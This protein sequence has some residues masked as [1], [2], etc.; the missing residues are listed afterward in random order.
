MIIS[1]NE[2]QSDGWFEDRLGLPTASNFSK[3]VTSKGVASKSQ[4]EYR[5][6]LASEI[7]SGNKG[8]NYTNKDMERGNELEPKARALYEFTNNVDVQEVGLCWKDETKRFG[9]SPDGLVG[10][11]GLIEI[12]CC[13]PEKVIECLD[14]GVPPKAYS[15]QQIQGQLLVSGRVWCD[16]WV[17]AEGLPPYCQRI[18][19]NEVFVRLLENELALFCDKLDILVEKIKQRRT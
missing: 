12:K 7:I 15:M 16:L 5:Y 6:L 11:D 9:A 8:V 10:K 18:M 1:E 17:Y 4:E 13:R 2:Q 19:R 3:I 14:K